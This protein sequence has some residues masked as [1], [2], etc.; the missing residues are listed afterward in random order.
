MEVVVLFN[1]PSQLI[2]L[3]SFKNHENKKKAVDFFLRPFLIH[4]STFISHSILASSDICSFRQSY[5]NTLSSSGQPTEKQ[6]RLIR[7]AGYAVV[8]NL[9]PCDFIENPLKDEE[10]I[11]TGLGMRYVHIP[12]NS[13]HPKS[14][15]F[16][17]FVSTMM[18]AS[19][20][21]VWVHC[22]INMRGAA[23]VYKYRCS[24]L[25]EDENIAIW[26][27]RE[28]W[29]PFGLWKKFLLAEFAEV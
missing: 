3:Y 10:A 12:V 18:D 22:A 6:F 9:A 4:L 15:D 28:I 17:R 8:V 14:E 11:V 13:F 19:D 2:K 16:V 20:E 26:D 25:G 27:L 29:E 21:K 5:S 23:F 7:E 24:V 1:L